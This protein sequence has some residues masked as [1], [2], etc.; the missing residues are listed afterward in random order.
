MKYEFRVV[1]PSVYQDG[2][3]YSEMQG[4]YTIAQSEGEAIMNIA[5]SMSVY[6]RVPEREIVQELAVDSTW[7]RPITTGVVN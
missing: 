4:H 5:Y 2:K 3:L 7:T 1:R 6:Y